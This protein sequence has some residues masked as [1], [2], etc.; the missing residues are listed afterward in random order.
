[1]RGVGVPVV[2]VLVRPQA[3]QGDCKTGRAKLTI[4][5]RYPDVQ[6]I[7]ATFMPKFTSLDMFSHKCF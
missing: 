4:S 5:P 7:E 3:N 6:T 1:M 2:F